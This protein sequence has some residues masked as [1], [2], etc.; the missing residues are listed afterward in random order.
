MKN[1]MIF[2]PQWI[3][4]TNLITKAEN[5]QVIEM[6][7]QSIFM[8]FL[9]YENEIMGKIYEILWNLIKKAVEV[10]I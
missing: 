9:K 8:K 6:W 10:S 4:F 2:F 5:F 3:T 7:L 1:C